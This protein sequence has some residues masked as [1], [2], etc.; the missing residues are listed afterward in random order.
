KL[1][2][3]RGRKRVPVDVSQGLLDDPEYDPLLAKAQPVGI[4]ARLEL[5]RDSRARGKAAYVCLQVAPK[6]VKAWRRRY[7]KICERPQLPHPVSQRPL[8]IVPT[9]LVFPR[10][11]VGLQADKI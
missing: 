8:D 2:R 9:I 5:D 6:P 3:G 10:H 7:K 11:G 4:L 1:D